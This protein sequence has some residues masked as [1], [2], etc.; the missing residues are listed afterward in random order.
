MGQHVWGHR[1]WSGVGQTRVH[2]QVPK[3]AH[4]VKNSVD[5]LALMPANGVRVRAAN[6]DVSSMGECTAGSPELLLTKCHRGHKCSRLVWKLFTCFFK[7]S[8]SSCRD[9][10]PKG[11]WPWSGL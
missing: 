9:F 3:I 7:E 11:A 5:E 2:V 6:P 1:A 4:A 8:T 10:A